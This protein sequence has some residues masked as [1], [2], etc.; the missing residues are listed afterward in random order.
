MITRIYDED[1][2]FVTQ[3]DHAMVSLEILNMIS[4]D[5]LDNSNDIENLKYAVRNHDLGWIDYDK[6]PKISDTY[7]VYTFQNVDYEIQNE[8]WL[9]SISLCNNPYSAILISEHFKYLILNSNRPD[10]V[11]KLFI[12]K[13]DS[14]IRSMFKGKVPNFDNLNNFKFDLSCLQITDLLSLTLCR[15]KIM[16]DSLFPPVYINDKQEFDY[17]I[18]KIDKSVYKF[19]SG[20]FEK[21]ENLIEIPYRQIEAELI[22]TPKKMKKSYI[23]AE[24]KYRRIYLIN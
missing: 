5:I 24:V 1:I 11:K 17:K 15:E 10:N 6:Y 23:D 13:A 9:K 12:E 16:K 14:I 7:E 19:T 4:K 8:L 22:Q 20:F 18:K 21:K 3:H 2:C